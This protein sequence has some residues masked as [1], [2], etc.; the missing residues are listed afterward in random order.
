[1]GVNI[2]QEPLEAAQCQPSM[3]M[4]YPQ[5]GQIPPIQQPGLSPGFRHGYNFG[6]S[7]FQPQQQLPTGL[8]TFQQQNL[9]Q[10]STSIFNSE[11]SSFYMRSRQPKS[12]PSDDD[13]DSSR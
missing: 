7:S 1:M 9:Q 11:H 6:Q 3:T 4:S 5:F 8:L 2:K 13:S 10:H 12:S